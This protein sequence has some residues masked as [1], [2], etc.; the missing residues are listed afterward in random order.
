MQLMC[1]VCCVG[2]VWN[3]VCGVQ[4]AM[5]IFFIY[6]VGVC[7]LLCGWCVE[8][9]LWWV[10]CDMCVQGISGCCTPMEILVLDS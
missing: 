3:V 9:G 8:C 7:G 4:C 5:C 1:V 2:G 6:L 10:M